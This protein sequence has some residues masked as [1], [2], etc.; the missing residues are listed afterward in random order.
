M[1]SYSPID[2][3]PRG[4][5]HRNHAEPQGSAHI[6]DV[7]DPCLVMAVVLSQVSTDPVVQEIVRK[8]DTIEKVIGYSPGM[9]C[10]KTQ[11]P[12]FGCTGHP[13]RCRIPRFAWKIL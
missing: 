10:P 9:P 11:N 3:K 12:H 7:I 1:V 8:G 5:L 2:T 6:E 13:D 4:L